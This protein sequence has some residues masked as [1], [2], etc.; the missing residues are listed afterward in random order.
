[1]I[2]TTQVAVALGLGLNIHVP[3][4]LTIDFNRIKNIKHLIHVFQVITLTL[5][6]LH[7]RPDVLGQILDLSRREAGQKKEKGQRS[8]YGV[9]N[10]IL[11]HSYLLSLQIAANEQAIPIR[12]KEVICGSHLRIDSQMGEIKGQQST[13]ISTSTI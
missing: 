12:Y 10:V 11:S 4:Q 7:N 3:Q 5:R 9:S 1:M 2:S 8:C 6:T 13:H